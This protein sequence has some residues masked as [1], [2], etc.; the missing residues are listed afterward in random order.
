MVWDAMLN[1]FRPYNSYGNGGSYQ[2]YQQ[3]YGAQSVNSQQSSVSILPFLFVAGLICV[4]MFFMKQHAQY[5][6]AVDSSG[7]GSRFDLNP[8]MAAP[9]PSG[10]DL[11][12]M[13]HR[14]EDIEFW[15]GLEPGTFIELTDA[16]SL[17][18]S[19]KRGLGLKGLRFT[20]ERITTM[21]DQEK[22]GKWVA[23]WITD[24]TQPLLLM[25]KACDEAIDWR[26]Y[27]QSG[28]FAAARREDA[29][30]RGDKWLF[31][32]PAD[33]A[34]FDA[35]DLT[36]TAEIDQQVDGKSLCYARKPQG[37]RQATCKE[38]PPR[39]GIMD[40]VATIVEYSTADEAENPELLILEMGAASRRTGQVSLYLG[41][42]IRASEI[43]IV[44][45]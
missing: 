34:N 24:R 41:S 18:D 7:I 9:K 22:F 17:E 5:S 43:N 10:P 19:Q 45:A 15:S 13:R 36:Y 25:A 20:V 32:P 27:Y 42:P 23:L 29:L 26:L 14:L 12:P 44:Q 21:T 33:E 31:E 11:R 4:G 3:P 1:S 35:A 37:E 2:N 38:N 8:P 16:Q 40:L 30:A 39:T 28:D 6:Y